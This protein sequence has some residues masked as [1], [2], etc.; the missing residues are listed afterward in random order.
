MLR[1]ARS[2]RSWAFLGAGVRTLA[3][4]PARTAIK[5]LA[6]ATRVGT[7]ASSGRW[8]QSSA[9]WQ[10][11]GGGG[12]PLGSI[13]ANQEGE[14]AFA[15][16]LATWA[17]GTHARLST[18]VRTFAAPTPP[19]LVSTQ[20]DH[21]CYHH[22]QAFLGRILTSRLLLAFHAPSTSSWTPPTSP[23]PL[24][25]TRA[26]ISF[27]FPHPAFPIPFPCSLSR[28]RDPGEVRDRLDRGGA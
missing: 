21:H 11:G 8:F 3:P 7:S 2:S 1:A 12:Q 13:F 18:R 4:L 23:R 16:V 19:G 15:V 6:R 9:A 27:P 17:A 28:R 10:Q 24:A 22:N 14:G 26:H 25:P 20:Q 5:S